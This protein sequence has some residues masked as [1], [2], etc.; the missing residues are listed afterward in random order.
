MVGIFFCFLI[1]R[2]FDYKYKYIIQDRYPRIKKN[3][4]NIKINYEKIN[5]IESNKI[6]DNQI[7]P[8]I[9]MANIVLEFKKD[10]KCAIR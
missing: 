2:L 7:N 9:K 6:S 1:I 5:L 3:K 8:W 4:I 10:E